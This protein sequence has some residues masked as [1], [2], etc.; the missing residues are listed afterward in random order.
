MV[1]VGKRIVEIFVGLFML[2][3]VLALFALA[4]KVSGLDMSVSEHDIRITA[5]FDNI[6]DLKVRA[7]VKIAGVRIGEVSKITLDPKT[8][9][10]KVE[11]AIAQDRD[12]IPVDSSASIFSESLLGSNYVSISPG[13]DDEAIK[14]GGEI[15]ET[16]PAI[17]LENLL[18]Q[19]IFTPKDKE[20]KK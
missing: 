9:R 8:F 20:N 11:M 3:G 7:P 16:N 5:V 2:C 19:A 10:A 18:G 4:L 1:M 15:E 6:G 17:I 14:N 13:F 12:N